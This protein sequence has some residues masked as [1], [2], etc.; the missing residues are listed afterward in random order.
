MAQA[1][2]YWSVK[3][4]I[5]DRDGGTAVPLA[6]RVYE[7]M[8]DPELKQYA[9]TEIRG[10]RLMPEEEQR[11]AIRR[12]AKHAGDVLSDHLSGSSDVPGPGTYTLAELLKEDQGDGHR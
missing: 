2:E 6:E 1:P 12:M 3:S 7:L 10:G 9:A 4:Y 8:R 11:E 5:M